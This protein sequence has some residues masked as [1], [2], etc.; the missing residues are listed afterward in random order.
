[1]N[2]RTRG[3]SRIAPGSPAR[4]LRAEPRPEPSLGVRRWSW[5]HLALLVVLALAAGL[6]FSGISRVGLRCDDEGAYAVDARLWH[7]CAATLTDTQALG[8]IRRGDKEAFKRRINAI[9]VDF[10]D[11]YRKSCQGYTFLGALLMFVTGDA[12]S[13]LLVTNAL[14]GTLAVLLAYMLGAVLFDRSAGLCSALLLAVSPYH[15]MYCRGAFTEATAGCF[16]LAGFVAWAWGRRH[17]WSW[18]RTYGLSGLAIGYASTCHYRSACFLLILLL[19]DLL[20]TRAGEAE[21][22]PARPRWRSTL[23]RWI[24]LGVGAAIPLLAI[25][26]V[27]LAARLA[28]SLSDSRLPLMTFLQ[29]S[30]WRLKAESVGMGGT[31]GRLFNAQVPWAYA[32]YVVHW[33]GLTAS[34]AALLAVA[35]VLRAKGAAK[36]PAVV[37]LAT[38]AMLLFQKHIVARAFSPA[39]PFLCLC[40]GAG[41]GWLITAAKTPPRHR[42]VVALVLTALVACTAGMQ[43]WRLVGRRSQLADACAF[44][45]ERGAAT[46]AVPWGTPK[47]RIYLDGT[48][49]EVIGYRWRGSAEELPAQLRSRGVRWMITDHQRWHYKRSHS[50]VGEPAFHWWRTVD[51]Q[52]KQEARLIAEFAHL[53]TQRWEFLAEGPGPQFVPEMTESGGGSLRIYD[54]QAAPTTT[55]EVETIATAPSGLGDQS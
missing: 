34:V 16:I 6:R 15:L 39:I 43:S 11:R 36:T 35:A 9:G 18:R 8:A 7:R 54:L 12:A 21:E 22:R 31:A 42:P 46:V 48:G 45:A 23:R 44:L 29:A 52:L 33:H 26:A 55:G 47:Y 3:S 37:V 38:I 5:V 53:S 27:F 24:W 10:T 19:V 17:G 14:C 41:L 40:L 25:E 13:A 50:G 51:R 30:W 2:H 20:A 28:A 1:M 32:G 4:A 49:V